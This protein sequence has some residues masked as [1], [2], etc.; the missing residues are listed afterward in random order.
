M[1]DTG[2]SGKGVEQLSKE[3]DW[4]AVPN[5]QLMVNRQRPWECAS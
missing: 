5:R 3:S 4:I 1:G 2:S